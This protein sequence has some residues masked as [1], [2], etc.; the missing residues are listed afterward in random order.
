MYRY[1][2]TAIAFDQYSGSWFTT[3]QVLD[4]LP[5]VDRRKCSTIT[6]ALT[7]SVEMGIFEKKRFGGRWKFKLTEHGKVVGNW[8]LEHAGDFDTDVQLYTQ[9]PP[10]VNGAK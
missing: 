7:R 6:N 5:M 8:A 9:R 10:E 4:Y 2:V 1:L 3:K